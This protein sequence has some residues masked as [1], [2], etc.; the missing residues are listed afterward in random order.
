MEIRATL[1]YADGMEVL[2]PNGHVLFDLVFDDDGELEVL[3]RSGRTIY[4]PHTDT[5]HLMECRLCRAE[6]ELETALLN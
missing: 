5:L 3:D 6:R 2:C 1:F 4:I